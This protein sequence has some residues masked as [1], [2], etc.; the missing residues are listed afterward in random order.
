MS[1]LERP[2]TD[3]TVKDVEVTCRDFVKFAI[4]FFSPRRILRGALWVSFFLLI[5]HAYKLWLWVNMCV[6]ERAGAPCRDDFSLFA[7]P[8]PLDFGVIYGENVGA[9]RSFFAV[10]WPHILCCF[11]GGVFVM[12]AYGVFWLARR[13]LYT[14]LRAKVVEFKRIKVATRRRAIVRKNK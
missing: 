6:L 3:V 4:F 7:T 9:S 1:P 14:W 10:D 13:Y 12:M 11:R 5:G 8:Y 2:I